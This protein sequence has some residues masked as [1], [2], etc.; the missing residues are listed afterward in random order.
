MIAVLLA[1]GTVF[2][3]RKGGEVTVTRCWQF[4]AENVIGVVTNGHD[5]FAAADGGRVFAV[6][7]TGEKLWQSDLGGEIMPGIGS[8]KGIVAVTTRS[9]N[10]NLALQRLSEATGLPASG[11]SEPDPP[12]YGASATPDHNSAATASVGDLIIL[13]NDAGLVTSLSGSG[14]VWKFKTGGGI[15]AILAVGDEFIVIS[16]DN[17]IYALHARN[18]GLEWKRRVQGRIG[19]YA[20]GK[21]FLF[22]SSLDQHGASL[23]DLTSGRVAA[24]IVLTD[25]DQIITDPVVL[26]DRFIV[27]TNGGLREFSLSGCGQK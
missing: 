21:G 16:R 27:A 23:I 24:Q 18:G 22:V 13:G 12:R 19:H 1:C 4:P 2:P 11:S 25:E 17:F 5:I 8:D 20:L 14:P 26:G 10:G 3:Q 9:T 6:S 7:S 15:S